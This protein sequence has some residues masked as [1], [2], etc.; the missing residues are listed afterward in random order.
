MLKKVFMMIILISGISFAES[1]SINFTGMGPTSSLAAKFANG[2]GVGYVKSGSTEVAVARWTPD[3]KLGD[4]GV[5]VDINIPLKGGNTEGIEPVVLRYAEYNTSVWG[6]RYGILN[7]VTLASG[8]LMSSYS[9]LSKGG[10][11]PTNKQVGVKGY[12]RYDTYELF[13]LGSWSSLY[14]VR[15]TDQIT[16]NLIIGGSYVTDVD[17]VNFTNPDSSKTLYPAMSGWSVDAKIPVFEGAYVYAEYARLLNY[18]GGFSGGVNMGYDLGIAKASFSAAKIFADKNFVPGYFN[19]NYETSPINLVSYEAMSATKD[20]YQI[21]FTADVLGRSRAWAIYESYVGSN[22]TLKAE[23]SADLTDDYYASA[24]IYQPN[25]IDARSLN[26]E[27][28]AILTGKVGYKVNSNMLMIVNYK[29]AYD[30]TAGK[31]VESQWYEVS[32]AF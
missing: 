19:E 28:G 20:G 21:K 31:V 27:E 9:T 3:F 6:V 15:I 7:N 14:A 1:S 16:P 8:L 13:V 22:S 24:S 4:L 11:F 30:P 25:F 2:I 32:L 17:G 10:V 18:G 23:A 26:V 5:G 12:Y 29:K